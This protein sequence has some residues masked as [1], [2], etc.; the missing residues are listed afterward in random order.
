MSTTGAA[1]DLSRSPA[2][3]ARVEAGEMIALLEKAGFGVTGAPRSSCAEIR[4]RE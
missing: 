3:E 4:S 1:P 2:D